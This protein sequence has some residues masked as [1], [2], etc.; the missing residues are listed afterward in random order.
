MASSY[1][2]V[3]DITKNLFSKSVFKHWNRLY[4]EVIESLSLEIIEK[5]V[6]VASGTRVSGELGSDEVTVG[7]HELRG[8][9]QTKQFCVSV[10]LHRKPNLNSTVPQSLIALLSSC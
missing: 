6:D 3:L 1:T 2:R 4:R 10:I 8:L 7:F 5:T 9:F